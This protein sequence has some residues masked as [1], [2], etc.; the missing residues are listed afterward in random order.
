MFRRIA[1]ALLDT[2]NVETGPETESKSLLYRYLCAYFVIVNV[3]WNRLIC[4]AVQLRQQ[5]EESMQIKKTESDV[6]WC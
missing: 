4:S 6:C 2:H 5:H 3:F 1:A